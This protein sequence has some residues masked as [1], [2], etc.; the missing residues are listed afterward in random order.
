MIRGMRGFRP[1]LVFQ[2]NELRAVLQPTALVWG[3]HDPVGDLEA[4]RLVADLLPD[5]ELH[6]VA[7]GHAPWW[8]EPELAAQFLADFYRRLDGAPT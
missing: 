1:D 8:G 6:V 3:D 7:A 2:E 5:A 4:A